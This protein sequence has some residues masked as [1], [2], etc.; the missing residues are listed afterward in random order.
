[1]T[2]QMTAERRADLL[3]ELEKLDPPPYADPANIALC[4]YIRDRILLTGN[5]A[6]ACGAEPPA[7]PS[8]DRL[9]RLGLQS[10]ARSGTQSRVGSTFSTPSSSSR[11]PPSTPPN[12]AGSATPRSSSASKGP[13]RPRR[14]EFEVTVYG[15]L[16]VRLPIVH[17]G[18]NA[19]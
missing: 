15:Y 1:M 5:V 12:A 14:D 19:H 13:G 10:L 11:G 17:F 18:E 8:R 6:A 3:S 16:R 4:A 2:L 7:T 9:S